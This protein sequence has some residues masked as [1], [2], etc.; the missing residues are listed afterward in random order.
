MHEKDWLE[1]YLLTLAH[2]R[3]KVETLGHHVDYSFC[4]IMSPVLKR[5]KKEKHYTDMLTVFPSESLFNTATFWQR[6]G[7]IN[8]Y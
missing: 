7:K 3:S 1:T 4:L 8:A 2:C 6:V 5:R